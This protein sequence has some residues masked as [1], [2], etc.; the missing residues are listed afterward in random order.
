MADRLSSKVFQS[1]I[2]M[3]QHN[4]V[5]GPMAQLGIF[6]PTIEA[7]T[8][9]M[10]SRQAI[11][12]FQ[13]D[14]RSDSVPFL[15]SRVRLHINKPSILTLLTPRK[16]RSLKWLRAPRFPMLIS[17]SDALLTNTR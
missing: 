1:R 14:P 2:W 13:L 10:A 17:Q 12:L 9:S 6:A 4:R 15:R 8:E 7:F 16:P 5:D 11:T 3:Q